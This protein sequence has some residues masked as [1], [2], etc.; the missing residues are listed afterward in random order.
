MRSRR[1][2]RIRRTQV[3]NELSIIIKHN[4]HQVPCIH[5]YREGISSKTRHE[6]NN[7]GEQR[8]ERI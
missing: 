8:E 6:H 4:K 1:E 3:L 7:H 5:I 2:Q